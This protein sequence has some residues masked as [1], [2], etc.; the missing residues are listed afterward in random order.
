MES[1]TKTLKS[2]SERA[3]E[4]KREYDADT[5]TRVQELQ[6][7]AKALQLFESKFGEGAIPEAKEVGKGDEPI[8]QACPLTDGPPVSIPKVA[9]VL[10][11]VR[12][13]DAKIF[14]LQFLLAPTHKQFLLAP[15]GGRKLLV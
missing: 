12:T 14:F 9:A 8:I 7:I 13:L 15:H 5:A 6:T 3:A 4:I 2:E 11:Q 1:D 10:L